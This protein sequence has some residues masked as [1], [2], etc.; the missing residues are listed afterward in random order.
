MFHCNIC[1]SSE[2]IE[3]KVDKVFNIDGEIVV[4]DK[5]PAKICKKCG[6]VSFSR[7]TLAQIQTIIYGEPK[8]YIQAKSFEFA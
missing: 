7:D 4:V 8:K 2:F 1:G 3:D 6:E 5:I